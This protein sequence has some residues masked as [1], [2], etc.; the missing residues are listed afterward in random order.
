[1]DANTYQQYLQ[2][3]PHYS[4]ES[5]NFK[6]RYSDR[7][8]STILSNLQPRWNDPSRVFLR[9][10]ALTQLTS[11]S[12]ELTTYSWRIEPTRTRPLC[13]PEG[14]IYDT[15]TQKCVCPQ[16]QVENP[17][18]QCVAPCTGGKVFDTA[19]TCVCP[20][21]QVENTVGQCVG[22]CT[23]G[24]VFDTAGTCVCP[25]GQVENTVGQCV[26]PCTG[27]KI[28]DA[29]GACVCPQGQVENTVGQCVEPCSCENCS[30][31]TIACALACITE[32][33][34]DPGKFPPKD[35][36]RITDVV[37]PTT[38]TTLTENGQLVINFAAVGNQTLTIVWQENLIRPR[39]EYHH[40]QT[41]EVIAAFTEQEPVI[42]TRGTITGTD[43]PIDPS[44]ASCPGSRTDCEMPLWCYENFQGVPC[45]AIIKA[46]C[47]Q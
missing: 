25:Q 40:P 20:Q 10:T 6:S 22:P 32:C 33:S 27:G 5:F 34:C 21:G 44:T 39:L 7:P 8:D 16:G 19:G 9:T 37:H 15:T 30:D 18:G 29:T 13:C 17:A 36:A 11:S 3:G 28:F 2:N 47:I 35:S 43:P 41:N 4:L 38:G 24:K 46:L 26:A 1:M 42:L 45:N 23:G 12:P 14:Q 31:S